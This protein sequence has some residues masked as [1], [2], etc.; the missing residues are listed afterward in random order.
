MAIL[1]DLGSDEER[2]AVISIRNAREALLRHDWVY[3]WKEVFRV[4]GIK[5]SPGMAAR[6][7]RLKEMADFGAKSDEDMHPQRS[8]PLG[9][10]DPG[11]PQ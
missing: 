11:E 2:T 4:A 3:R 7:W 8:A 5:P 6:E 10:I 9:R 1:K